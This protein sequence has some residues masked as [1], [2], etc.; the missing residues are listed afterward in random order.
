MFSARNA[1]E[2]AE[3]SRSLLGAD[4][5]TDLHDVASTLGVSATDLRE[6]LVYKTPYPAVQVLAAVVAHYGVDAGWLLTGEYSPSTHRANEEAGQPA[7]AQLDKL[8]R[9]E[10]AA[11]GFD[12]RGPAKDHLAQLLSETPPADQHD[13][14]S[15]PP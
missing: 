6:I 7:Q 1:S 12:D 8:L 9:D 15:S 10:A 2:L 14:G 11:I 3:R 13:P 4:A 5:T